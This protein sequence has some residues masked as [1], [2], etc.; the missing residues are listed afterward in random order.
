MPASPPRAGCRRSA[1]PT[2]SGRA[3]G[4]RTSPPPRPSSASRSVVHQFYDAR[5]AA[6]ATVEPNPAHLA[7]ARLEA[8]GR[9]RPA[10]GH[11]EHRRPAR[12][13]RLHPGAAHARRA[14]LRAVPRLRC[15]G[16]VGG[17]PRRLPAVPRLPEP[18]LRPDVVWFGEVPYELD[19]IF[20]ALEEADLFVSIGTSGAVYPAAGLRPGRVGVRRPHARAQPGPERG[21]PLLRRGPAR[22][23]RRDRAGLG[24]RVVGV[25]D[26]RPGYRD[27][28]DAAARTARSPSSSRSVR[29]RSPW[30]PPRRR[31]AVD[32]H[33]AA[34]RDGAD[35]RPVAGRREG[36]DAGVAR[37]R[38]RSGWPARRRTR[39]W[40]STSTSTTPSSRPT[41]TGAARSR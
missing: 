24:R 15:P 11:P 40:R 34:K 23:R 33:H 18:E 19:R 1:T 41:T 25:S 6:L 4:S 35:P 14:A 31:P 13:R 36:R 16:R 7:L 10:R 21:Q 38:A 2:G 5:R 3:T 9:R 20:T 22:P 26:R 30:R 8:R 39:S 28:H 29:P 37:L 12:A 17:R 32:G 27:R